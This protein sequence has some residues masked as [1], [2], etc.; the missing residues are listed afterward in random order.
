VPALSEVRES[1]P[2][3]W[4]Y[5]P[6]QYERELAAVWYRDWICVGREDLLPEPGDYFV[7]TIGNQGI[8][9]TRD[10]TGRIR[11][12]HN[13]CR[14]RGSVLCLEDAGRFRNGRI[15]CPYH[16]WTYGTDGRLLATPGRIESAGFDPA[17]Y[18][19]YDVR[20]DTWRG[21]IHAS[22][23]EEPATDLPTQLGAEAANLAHWPLESLRTVHREVRRVSCNWKIF[24]ENYSEC[25]HCPRVHPELCRIMPLYRQ[26]VF[27]ASDL[28]GWRPADD[29]DTGRGRV[30]DGAQTW[31][32]DGRSSLPTMPGLSAAD[33]EA[34][35]AFASFTA[36]MF[37]VA[38]PDYA[39]TV[40]IVPTGPE[41]IDLVVD[42]LLPA[43]V[44]V[45]DGETLQPI[46]D[47]AGTVME[48][49]VRVCE[50]N[51]RGLKSRSHVAGVLVGQERVLWEFHEWLRGRLDSC[52]GAGA[53][54]AS[55]SKPSCRENSRRKS[56]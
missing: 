42:W 38:H 49:D 34:G 40:R 24:W 6:V 2:A 16:T 1:L 4:Y 41:S 7:A 8:I 17:A 52:P 43:D 47:L 9:V 13:T 36:S 23:A 28:P 32:L 31:T 56:R 22:L 21:F 55:A 33:I 37:I 19:L 14:H 35:V 39:R 27:D 51:Q 3:T 54:T 29:D 48:Q 50:L 20:V 30:R 25:Y 26:A 10:T 12:F 18:S 53:A 5:D 11:G 44:D 45:P 15:I 46:L